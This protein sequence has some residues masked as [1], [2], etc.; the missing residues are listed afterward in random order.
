MNNNVHFGDGVIDE[1][2]AD[3]NSRVS[4]LIK[5]V[6][7]ATFDHLETKVKELPEKIKQLR[8]SPEIEQEITALWS[9]YLFEEGLVS[10]GY[11]GL[12]DDL[13]ISNFHQEGYLDGLYIGYIL[14]MMALTDN[15][16]PKNAILSVRDYIRPNLIGH[17]YD[18][19]DEFIKRYKDEKYSWIDRARET[20]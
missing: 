6:I 2:K 12:P 4:G 1:A 8:N 7:D 10:K 14:A 3:V 15:D 16:I 17:H 18:D 11:K 20:K 9:E 13:L 19:R 5:I